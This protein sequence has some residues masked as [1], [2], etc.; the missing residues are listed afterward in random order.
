MLR[1][2]GCS[3]VSLEEVPFGTAAGPG[4]CMQWL[5][6]RTHARTASLCLGALTQ[7]D[8]P[9]PN[10]TRRLEGEGRLMTQQGRDAHAVS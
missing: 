3:E 9:A 1:C 5:P 10:P 4:S 8:H 2:S 7:P 6:N